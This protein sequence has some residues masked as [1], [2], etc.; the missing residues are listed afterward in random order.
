MD[1][2]SMHHQQAVARQQAPPS[3]RQD[4]SPEETKYLL[5]RRK[6]ALK[7]SRHNAPVPVVHAVVAVEE[8]PSPIDTLGDLSKRDYA[9]IVYAKSRLTEGD[10]LVVVK[11]PSNKPVCDFTGFVLDTVFRVNSWKLLATGSKVFTKMLSQENQKRSRQRPLFRNMYIPQDVQFVLDL[12][13]ATDDDDALELVTSLS[14]PK[15]ILYWSTTTSRLGI[16]VRFV[17]GYDEKVGPQQE[18]PQYSSGPTIIS[19]VNPGNGSEGTFDE[20]IK[21]ATKRS[22]KDTGSDT[23]V[24]LP[25]LLPTS[26]KQL[27]ADYCGIRHCAGIERMLQLIEGKEAR[28]DSAPKVWTVAMLAGFFD[29]ASSV[30]DAI[31]TWVVSQRNGVIVEILPES[32]LRLGLVLRSELI[33]R[34]AFA[35][36]VSEEALCIASQEDN[37]PFKRVPR[38]PFGRLR[39]DIDDDALNMIQHAGRSF[40][41]RIDSKVKEL[42]DINMLWLTTLP[43]YQKLTTFES[44]FIRGRGDEKSVDEQGMKALL[45]LRESLA[46][47]V[48]GRLFYCL[49]RQLKPDQI[50]GIE[51]HRKLEEYITPNLPDN[52][53]ATYEAF[54]S[55]Q[56]IMTRPFWEMVRSMEWTASPKGN[57]LLHVRLEPESSLSKNLTNTDIAKTFRIRPIDMY[58][59]HSAR[60]QLNLA[61]FERAT[62]DNPIP[63]VKPNFTLDNIALLDDWEDLFIADKSH[64]IVNY[65]NKLNQ[66]MAQGRELNYTQEMAWEYMR[67]RK[68]YSIRTNSLYFDLQR[69]MEEVRDYL[70]STCDA[71]TDRGENRSFSLPQTLVCLTDA[72]MK[73][74]PLFAG[75]FED[76]TGGVYQDELPPAVGGP[77]G[78]G[79]SYHTGFSIASTASSTVDWDNFSKTASTV[80]GW[81]RDVDDGNTD[82]IDRRRVAD[83]SEISFGSKAF[84]ELGVQSTYSFSEIDVEEAKD[85]VGKGKGKEVN[86]GS[87]NSMAIAPQPSTIDSL[88][89]DNF[90]EEGNEDDFESE[91]NEDDDFDFMDDSDDTATEKGDNDEEM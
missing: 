24:D 89:S 28:L 9:A 63:I 86:H 56:R 69:L 32:C 1:K 47:Y 8:P 66:E 21:E 68:G 39:E 16:P 61:I 85:Y 57:N 20:R 58:A 83:G 62:K 6:D 50:E 26:T 5:E 7:H 64:Y 36:L 81:S 65:A 22:L 27:P 11:Y 2:W 40:Y 79:P 80:G 18:P 19:D 55:Q 59:I 45:E 76:G 4:V 29:C 14:C 33:T 31:C 72:E 23:P 71:M 78:P 35:V 70:F 17:G 13:P 49:Y 30:V 53:R 3:T 90:L 44:D 37:V 12:T 48:R 73:Y 43:E 87:A 46:H 88:M 42:L 82:H 15:G 34:A 84:D 51:A 60:D 52:A 67:L 77:S 74:L 75:G 54:T 25:I 91:E 38:T 10:T 41:D